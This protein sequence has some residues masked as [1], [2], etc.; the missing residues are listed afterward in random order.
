[1]TNHAGY[2]AYA[3]MRTGERQIPPKEAA[4]ALRRRIAGHTP[5]RIRLGLA[6]KAAGIAVKTL[7]QL[8][9]VFLLGCTAF[10]L[11][12]NNALVALLVMGVGLVY[13]FGRLALHALHTFVKRKTVG[14]LL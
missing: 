6:G 12:G 9:V 1:M 7:L 13:V 3:K 8:I 11:T 2:N 5:L 10:A 14:V 4:A